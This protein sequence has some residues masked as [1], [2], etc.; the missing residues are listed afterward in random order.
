[1]DLK[2]TDVDLEGKVVDSSIHKLLSL[3]LLNLRNS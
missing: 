3:W 1:M 2:G